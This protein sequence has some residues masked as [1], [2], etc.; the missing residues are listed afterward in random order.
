MGYDAH[1]ISGR[2]NLG[3]GG[4]G[5]HS[6][7]EIDFADGSTYCYDPAGLHRQGMAN[8]YHFKYKQKGT[9]VYDSPVRMN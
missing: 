3:E 6:W 8:A 2:V 7:V 5:K 9:W 1:Q 4:F